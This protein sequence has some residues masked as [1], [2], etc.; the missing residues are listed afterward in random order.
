MIGA[1]TLLIIQ[2]AIDLALICIIVYLLFFK[3]IRDE[4]AFQNYRTAL[5]KTIE[6]SDRSTQMM[7]QA[8]AGDIARFE[9]LLRSLEAKEKGLRIL[10]KKSEFAAKSA[11]IAS[12]SRRQ[13]SSDQYGQVIALAEQG[14]THEEIEQA[15][16]LPYHEIKLILDIRR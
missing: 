16:G 13:E 6:E 2:V 7:K 3:K 5:E 12:P 9:D 14:M 10:L 15:T 1:Q 11:P 4:K 8:L